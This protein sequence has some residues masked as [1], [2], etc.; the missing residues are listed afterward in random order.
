MCVGFDCFKLGMLACVRRVWLFQT[1]MLAYVRRVWL[2]QTWG[3]SM[4][5]L[6]LAVSNLGC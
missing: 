5:A 6:G 4:R 2:F 3:A 1:C